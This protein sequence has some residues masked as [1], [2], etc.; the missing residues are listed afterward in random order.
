MYSF[1]E[2]ETYSF[3]PG[4][5]SF[6]LWLLGRLRC[7]H[8]CTSH[9]RVPRLNQFKVPAATC[10]NMRESHGGLRIGEVVPA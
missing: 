9:C 2:D 3:L 5:M 1:G 4:L 6:R 10:L 8:E 7:T